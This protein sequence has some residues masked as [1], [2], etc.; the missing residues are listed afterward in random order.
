VPGEGERGLLAIDGA[1]MRLVWS[2]PL[3]Q[4]ELVSSPS[5]IP[6]G[7]VI[8]SHNFELVAVPAATGMPGAWGILGGA[9]FGIAAALGSDGTVYT[10][11]L[12]GK[13]YAVH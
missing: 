7:L 13:V 9:G 6:G 2:L 12:D 10:G 8:W 4:A 1:T 11:N 5:V 3:L